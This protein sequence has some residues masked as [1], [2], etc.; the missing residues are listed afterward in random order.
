VISDS[1]QQ[2]TLFSCCISRQQGQL[3]QLEEQVHAL[4]PSPVGT[5]DFFLAIFLEH[6]TLLILVLLSNPKIEEIKFV[7]RWS[8]VF[9]VNKNRKSI[10]VSIMVKERKPV[11]VIFGYPLSPAHYLVQ[12]LLQLNFAMAFK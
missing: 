6:V 8:V 11:V 2:R 5:F 4:T 9:Q 3:E 12:R 1:N 7:W 10:T